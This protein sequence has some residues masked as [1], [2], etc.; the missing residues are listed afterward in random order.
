[1]GQDDD[2]LPTGERQIQRDPAP[3][4]THRAG[5]HPKAPHE[6]EGSQSPELSPVLRCTSEKFAL[7]SSGKPRQGFKEAE[8]T[9]TAPNMR[10]RP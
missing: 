7:K 10:I 8:T 6:L 4:E 9:P 5:W 3:H 1:M 2:S